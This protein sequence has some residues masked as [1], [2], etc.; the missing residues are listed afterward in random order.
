MSSP[1]AT[2][3]MPLCLFLARAVSRLTLATRT[4]V[5]CCHTRLHARAAAEAS[6]ALRVNSGNA[7]VAL[8]SYMLPQAAL[9]AQA[10]RLTQAPPR[11][12]IMRRAGICLC[13]RSSNICHHL[14]P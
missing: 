13:L 1:P 7:S 10:T 6:T 14:L 11:R 8:P 9:T 5:L 2:T 3:T 12:L 4:L